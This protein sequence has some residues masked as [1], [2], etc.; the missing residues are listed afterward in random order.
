M[1]RNE[2]LRSSALIGA[3]AL[4]FGCDTDSN[5]TAP[6]VQS[7]MPPFPYLEV[8]ESSNYQIGYKIGNHFKL[9]FNE[10]YARLIADK[11][12]NPE[13]QFNGMSLMEILL[14][15]VDSDPATFRDP[16][17]NA[18]E[19]HFPQYLEELKGMAEGADVPF[20]YLFTSMCQ[21][22][23]I[24]LLNGSKS[25][26][27]Q[28]PSIKGCS[29]VSYAGS[30]KL[31]LAHNEDFFTAHA[32]LMYVVKVSQPG[33][34]TFMCLNYPGSVLGI[35]P[36]MNDAGMVFSGNQ[37]DLPTSSPGVPFV[38]LSRAIYE[39]KSISD[40]KSIVQFPNLAY[41]THFNI[42][43]FKEKKIISAEV[44]PGKYEIHE[45]SNFYVH[46]NHFVLPT[47]EGLSVVDNNSVNRRNMLINKSGE[48]TSKPGEVNSDLITGWMSSHDGYPDAV[49]V[50]LDGGLTVAHSL[51]D[52]QNETW[53]LYR[54][55]PCN[56]AYKTIK[57]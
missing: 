30:N 50:H 20:N 1:K 42:G 26:N 23:I 52:F 44:M 57:L 2:F 11:I 18:V 3:A 24:G 16:F 35:P 28:K 4:A 43:S 53:K 46:T 7:E 17:Y 34:P 22:E 56:N 12:N 5:P 14:Y 25:V 33:K 48:Y 51:F 36:G 21:L 54:G 37:V 15:F 27:L 39:A 19:T 49:C 47:M 55:N 40:A 9:Q 31:F 45:V 29:T 8:S 13:S 10:I 41:A 6:E 38:F 32:D